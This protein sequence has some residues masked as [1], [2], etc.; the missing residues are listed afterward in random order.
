VALRVLVI[1]VHGMSHASNM[2]FAQLH[3]GVTD[4]PS[5]RR[6]FLITADPGRQ[7]WERKQWIF[8]S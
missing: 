1:E 2:P 4:R 8:V 7:M 3:C 6:L 5:L